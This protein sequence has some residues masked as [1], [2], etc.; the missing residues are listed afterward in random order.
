MT[1]R[2]RDL[3]DSEDPVVAGLARM[4]RTAEDLEPPRGAQDRVR[5]AL[6]RHAQ[7]ERAYRRPATG[8]PVAIESLRPSLPALDAIAAVRAIDVDPDPAPVASE[9]HLRAHA[10]WTPAPWLVPNGIDPALAASPHPATTL[11]SAAGARGSSPVAA[12][13]HRPGRIAAAAAAVIAVVVTAAAVGPGIHSARSPAPPSEAPF[14]P[15]AALP[16]F[17]PAPGSAASRGS[18]GAAAPSPGVAEALA[19]APASTAGS[20][21]SQAG[22]GTPGGSAGGGAP[23]VDPGR[24]AV[25]ARD[26]APDPRRAGP[27]APSTP[28]APPGPPGP[29]PHVELSVDSSPAGAQV[30][31]HGVVLGTT[32]F[33]VA[34]PRR[35]G[36]VVLVVRLAGHLDQRVVVHPTRALTVH[37]PLVPVAPPRAEARG[38]DDSVN[39]FH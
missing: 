1:R 14:A 21:P 31:L 13:R 34:L 38:H 7:F 22:P 5:E 16:P 39:P 35:A 28:S 6:A 3:V 19:Q 33:H 23:A 25:G 18:A 36:E 32:P 29:R 27:P 8:R 17:A 24:G 26:D 2:L 15:S 37:V 11:S 30:L 20:G 10:S 9:L 12:R 4:I